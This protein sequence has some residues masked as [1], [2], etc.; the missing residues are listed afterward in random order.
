MSL[1]EETK[2]HTISL[3]GSTSEERTKLHSFF[4]KNSLP[5]YNDILL[6]T[7]VYWYCYKFFNAS[8]QG[9]GSGNANS[10]FSNLI[11]IK[12]FLEKFD[13]PKFSIAGLYKNKKED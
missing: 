12:D 4:I 1:L 6:D 9:H 3:K 8:F 5:L 2:K 10:S 13:K 7:E 11:S